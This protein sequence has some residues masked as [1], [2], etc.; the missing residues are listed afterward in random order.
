MN[1]NS[2]MAIENPQLPYLDF[3]ARIVGCRE[4]Y[5]SRDKIFLVKRRVFLASGN[6]L[7]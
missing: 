5:S 4:N 6:V 1:Y 7:P 3:M 2:D